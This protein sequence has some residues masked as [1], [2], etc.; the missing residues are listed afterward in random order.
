MERTNP[1]VRQSEQTSNT[2]RMQD[3]RTNPEVRRSEQTSNTERMRDV[4]TNPEVRQNEQTNNTE[5]TGWHKLTSP[6]SHT[7]PITAHNHIPNEPTITEEDN[8]P[9]D[10]EK[11]STRINVCKQIKRIMMLFCMTS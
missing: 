6:Q 1:D 11:K 3:V 7:Q 9:S 10:L 2:V 8:Y 4:R 5:S